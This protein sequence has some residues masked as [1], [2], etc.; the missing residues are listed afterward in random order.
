VVNNKHSVIAAAICVLVC[1]SVMA[2][3]PEHSILNRYGITSEQLPAARTGEPVE[4][5]PGK[6]RFE[7]SAHRPWATLNLEEAVTPPVTGNISIDRALQQERARCLRL[8][9]EARQRKSGW[10]GCG[11]S[12][13]GPA[14]SVGIEFAPIN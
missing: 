2:E 11:E 9:D 4:P 10:D 5:F 12:A 1:D 7:I 13:L 3:L 6:T 8:R 14:I